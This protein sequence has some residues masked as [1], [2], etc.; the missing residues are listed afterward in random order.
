M[1]F[2]TI[3]LLCLVVFVSSCASYRYRKSADESLLQI[4][5][6]SLDYYEQ[7]H[8][9]P[10]SIETLQQYSNNKG[11]IIDTSPFEY[12]KIEDGGAEF[13]IKGTPQKYGNGSVGPMVRD[14]CVLSPK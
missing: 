5:T 9:Y 8:R 3:A 2:S 1:R 13:R 6:V 12:L 14:I 7:Y 10:S 11:I 4:V